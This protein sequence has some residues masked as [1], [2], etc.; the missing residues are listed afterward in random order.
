MRIHKTLDN[1]G[2]VAEETDQEREIR[3]KNVKLAG[4]LAVVVLGIYL[5]FIFSQL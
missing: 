4:I 2:L 3:R 5:G 1:I